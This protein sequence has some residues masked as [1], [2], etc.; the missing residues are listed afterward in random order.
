MGLLTGIKVLD[1]TYYLPGPNAAMRL[2]KM[3]ATV[4]KVEPPE[5]DPAKT[6]GGGIVHEANNIG[7]EIV[8]IDLKTSVGQQMMMELIKT[9]DVLLESF[10]PGVM[11]RLGFSYEVVKK[12]KPDIVYCSMTGYGRWSLLAKFGSHDI[13]YMALSGILSQFI[14]EKRVPIP[15]QNTIA[16][17]VGALNVTEG[18]LAAL[19]HKFKTGEGSF[20][21]IAI[22]DAVLS[23]QETHLV[24][25]DKGIS[26]RGIPEIDGTRIAYGLYRTKDH[27]HVVLGALEP[28]FWDN[29]CTF[30]D[31]PEWK[32]IAFKQRGTAEH[33]EVSTF[34]G[35][36]TW[37][38]W[39]D[40]SLSTDFCVTPVMNIS[41]LSKHPYWQSKVLTIKS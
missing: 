28:K 4:I 26:E 7:K 1:V 18:I 20:V 8:T 3:G 9:A 24:Y 38:E 34:F 40:I 19:V 33:A 27:R 17:Y 15:P 6:L 35:K 31:R 12:Y 16:D 22:A 10:R 2:A 29:F 13:N 23:F 41:E 5:G 36:Y 14:N 30:A 11:E 32:Q 21:D 25:L 39:L 37:D